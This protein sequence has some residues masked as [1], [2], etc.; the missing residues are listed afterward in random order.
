VRVLLPLTPPNP[1]IGSI[2]LGTSDPC[3]RLSPE[4]S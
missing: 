4:L 2:S 3:T 1:Y